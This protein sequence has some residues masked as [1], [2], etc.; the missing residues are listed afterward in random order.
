MDSWIGDVR[1]RISITSKKI[2]L[3]NAGAGPLTKDVID[4]IESF[5]RIWNDEGEPW[6]EVL[7]HI[8]E[9]RRLFGSLIGGKLNEIAAVPGVSFGLNALLSSLKLDK[10]TNAVASS[11]NFPTGF[12]TLHALRSRGVLSEVR[13]AEHSDGYVSLDTYERLIDDKTSIVLVDYVSWITGYRER[14][15]EIASIAHE[16]GAI[17]IVDSFH[18]TGVVPID[19]KADDIDALVCGMYKWLMGPHGAG[20]VYVREELIDDLEP[21][22]SGWMAIEDSVI[23]RMLRGERLFE[24]PFN[25]YEFKPARDATM[26]EWGT[27]P[28]IAFEGALAALKF[29]IRF[30]MPNRYGSHTSKIVRRLMDLLE[31]KGYKLVTPRSSYAAI[32]S[33]RHE[34]PYELASHLKSRGIIVSPRP[35]IIRVSPHFYNTFEEIEKF[36]DSVVEFDNKR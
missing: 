17:V 2:Y 19:V 26:L 8:V 36:V 16:H 5:L 18:A 33:F 29:A 9:S 6:D 21:M 10:G 28:A 35:G 20:F 15:R 24:R 13:I 25:I 32:V 27:W 3:D 1:S 22:L 23:K 34:R 30:D 12:Y 14:I 31:S 4:S 7:E 11:L